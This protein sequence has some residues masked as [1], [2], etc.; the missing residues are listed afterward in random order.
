MRIIFRRFR[1]RLAR[2][3]WPHPTVSPLDHEVFKAL[4]GMD[5]WG[6]KE[7]ARHVRLTEEYINGG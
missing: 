6:D 5:K 2:W 3:F 7:V 4:E 1:R